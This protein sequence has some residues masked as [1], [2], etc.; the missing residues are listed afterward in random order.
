M[1]GTG[2]TCIVPYTESTL[3]GDVVNSVKK[4]FPAGSLE[5]QSLVYFSTWMDE[6]KSIMK[7]YNI[8]GAST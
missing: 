8:K 5:G 1:G 3:V 6:N 2:S 7:D 4:L